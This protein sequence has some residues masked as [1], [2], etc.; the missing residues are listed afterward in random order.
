VPL[1]ECST[2]CTILRAKASGPSRRQCSSVVAALRPPT[3]VRLPT[4][5]IL[6]L[7][8]C[9]C[10]CVCVARA[11]VC[12]LRVRWYVCAVRP[13]ACAVGPSL[14]APYRVGQRV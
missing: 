3:P 2:R 1:L 11:C 10:V 9:V 5:R 8:V 12:V 14:M 13:V 6:S 7:C 4:L